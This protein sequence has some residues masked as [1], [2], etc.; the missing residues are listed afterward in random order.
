MSDLDQLR[1]LSDRI[2]PPPLDTLRNTA[3]ARDRRAVAVVATGAAA[4]IV[5]ATATILLIDDGPSSTQPADPPDVIEVTRPIVYADGAT[6]HLGDQTIEA[7]SAVLEVDVTDAGVAFRTSDGQIWFADG[8]STEAIG[9]LGQ[10]K[11]PGPD[12]DEWVPSSRYWPVTSS[13]GWM[14]S[15]NSGSHVAWFDFTEP[16]SPTIVVFDTSTR[17]VVVRTEVTVPAGGWAGLHSVT[18]QSAYWFLDPDPFADDR[19]P[20]VRLDLATGD[21]A[22]ISPEEYLADIGSRPARTLQIS[23]AEQGFA[24]YEIVEGPGWQFAV[25]RG[26]LDPMGMQP[27]QVRNGLTGERLALDAP[28]GYPN[29]N[30]VWLVQWLDDDTVVLHATNGGQIDLIECRVSTGTC[31]VAVTAPESIVVPE[32]G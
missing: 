23:H 24:L 26:E 13:V 3:R 7:A 10:P 19:M 30:P 14:V 4:A 11:A 20:Q 5:V 18:D 31:T 1:V 2:V 29:S 27:L 12:L 8:E 16:Q 21:Q 9:Q 25:S 32:A 22:P 17:E 6:I 28:A 15:A